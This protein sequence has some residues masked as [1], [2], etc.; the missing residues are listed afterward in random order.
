[1][2]NRDKVYRDALVTEQSTMIGVD[3]KPRVMVTVTFYIP[4]TQAGVTWSGFKINPKR[5]S[6]CTKVGRQESIVCR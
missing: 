1:M 5:V 2:S 6:S 3:Y 4:V